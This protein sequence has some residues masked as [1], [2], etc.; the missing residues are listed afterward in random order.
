MKFEDLSENVQII[1]AETLRCVIQNHATDNHEAYTHAANNIR[2][3]FKALFDENLA[4]PKSVNAPSDSAEER[5]VII[6]LTEANIAFLKS[7]SLSNN[8][9]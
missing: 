3:A 2:E 8:L 4:G 6:G 9:K 5:M 1:A 7:L